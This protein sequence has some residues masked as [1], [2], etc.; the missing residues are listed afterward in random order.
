MESI[1]IQIDRQELQDKNMYEYCFKCCNFYLN[2]E[3]HK[4]YQI[5]E[6]IEYHIVDIYDTGMIG[7]NLL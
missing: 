6:D 7:I 2:N 4:C 3:K 1:A 5:E